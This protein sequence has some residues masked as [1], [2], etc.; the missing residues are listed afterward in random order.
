MSKRIIFCIST[1]WRVQKETFSALL[2]FVWENDRPP[3]NSLTKASEAELWCFIWSV[4]E[5]TV[6]NVG[7]S[8][9]HR[10]HYDVTSM[11]DYILLWLIWPFIDEMAPEMVYSQTLCI[12]QIY[13]TIYSLTDACSI[14]QHDHPVIFF[15]LYNQ[16]P[17]YM[18]FI[19]T[20]SF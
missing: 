5:Q 8:R 14:L 3:V 11:T 9:R 6:G 7:D 20:T 16:M 18:I 10:A 2:A 4:P 13:S 15:R 1:W 17:L 12:S 19:P